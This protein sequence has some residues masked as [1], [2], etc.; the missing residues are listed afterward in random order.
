MIVLLN[1]VGVCMGL[2]CG[3]DVFVLH[4]TRAS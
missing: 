3:V 2:S 1:L 4:E